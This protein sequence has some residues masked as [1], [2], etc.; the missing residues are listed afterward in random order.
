[1]ASYNK[2]FLM[3]NVTR[4]PQVKQLPSQMV[5]AE[6]GLATNR[7]Y[8]NAAGED[9]EDVCFVDVTA[10]G[11]QAE[12]ISQYVTKG[13]PLFVEGRLKLDTWEDKKDGSKRSKLTVVLENFQFLPS[14]DRAAGG[15]QGAPSRPESAA[16]GASLEDEIDAM[17]AK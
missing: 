3:G 4:D 13:K 15:G 10:F 2:V 16:S 6:F 11:R 12:T 8:K 7:K 17:F 5:V 9:K 14:G 1:M